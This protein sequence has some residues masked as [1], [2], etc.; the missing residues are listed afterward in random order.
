MSILPYICPSCFRNLCLLRPLQRVHEQQ[1]L[2]KAPYISLTSPDSQQQ[3]QQQQQQEEEGAADE[4][5][6]EARPSES[7]ARPL[8]MPTHLERRQPSHVQLLFDRTVEDDFLE[9]LTED[10]DFSS[11]PY[12]NPP[13]PLPRRGRGHYTSA[14]PVS[15]HRSRARNGILHHEEAQRAGRLLSRSERPVRSQL[16]S[17]F[18]SRPQHPILKDKNPRIRKHQVETDPGLFDGFFSQFV[19]G[20]YSERTPQVASQTLPIKF[21]LAEEDTST[22]QDTIRGQDIAAAQTSAEVLDPE[23]EAEDTSRLSRIVAPASPP[24]KVYPAFALKKHKPTTRPPERQLALLFHA[25]HRSRDTKDSHRFHSDVASLKKR[26]VKQ[27]DCNAPAQDCYS[28]FL[29]LHLHQANLSVAVWSKLCRSMINAWS[30]RMNEDIPS[31]SKFLQ[32][33]KEDGISHTE[34]WG[35]TIR[36]VL[37]ITLNR[38]TNQ[39]QETKQRTVPEHL[40]EIVYLWSQ[41]F[42]HHGECYLRN[43]F[44]TIEQ[45]VGVTD[46]SLCL[47]SEQMKRLKNQQC[48]VEED[49]AVILG[50]NNFLVTGEWN[51]HS[52]P[53]VDAF[54][55]ISWLLLRDYGVKVRAEADDHEIRTM[56]D[57]MELI[58]M[59]P[60]LPAYA[61]NKKSVLHTCLAEKTRRQS[62]DYLLRKVQELAGDEKTP[63][64]TSPDVSSQPARPV[65]LEERIINKIDKALKNSN[66]RRLEEIWRVAEQTFLRSPS[67]SEQ[68]NVRKP[69]IST[70][71]TISSRVYKQFFMAYMALQRPTRAIEVWNSMI[72]NGHRP[73]LSHWDAMLN[74]CGLAR[75]LDGALRM[76][77][78]ALESD[79]KPDVKLWTTRIHSLMS[80]RRPDLGIA[81]FQEMAL[82]WVNKATATGQTN[83]HVVGNI[84]D[85]PKPN[86]QCLNTAISGLV[87]ARKFEDLVRLISWS[88]KLGIKPDS[89]TF[90]PLIQIALKDENFPLALKALQQMQ[91][92]GIEPDV[93]TFTLVLDMAIKRDGISSADEI[94]NALAPLVSGSSHDNISASGPYSIE[95][96]KTIELE[97]QISV[98]DPDDVT[99]ASVT[100][101]ADF[102]VPSC[103][104]QYSSSLSK[105][106]D[107]SSPELSNDAFDSA[108]LSTGQSSSVKEKSA[109]A[110]LLQTMLAN[111]TLKPSPHTYTTLISGLLHSNPP[112]PEA[113]HAL[114]SYISTHEP[115]ALSSQLY[116][117]LISFHFAQDP[118]E[119]ESVKWLWRQ[120]KR[121]GAKVDTR[122]FERLIDGWI[123]LGNVAARSQAQGVQ[124]MGAPHAF[125]AWQASRQKGWVLGFDTLRRLLAG[126]LRSRLY[127]E[128]AQIVDGVREQ[129]RTT[130]T[131]HYKRAGKGRESF[132]RLVKQAGLDDTRS[133]PATCEGLYAHEDRADDRGRH[134]EPEVF[135]APQLAFG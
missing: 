43:D 19:K 103:N 75:D 26:L 62:K 99:Q 113:A 39:G 67:E 121:K 98:N 48:Q 38:A 107:P 135:E 125:D 15:L 50:I 54:A 42:Q 10:R 41:M 20:R 49:G 86:T 80:C 84:G 124:A 83:Y 89:Y 109:L 36:I 7:P 24:R 132:W 93:A 35:L 119:L 64:V 112:N 25:K 46:L 70:G 71:L 17:W 72:S 59:L 106:I 65:S 51:C 87:A 22:A 63:N 40:R 47:R 69:S 85:I 82:N 37:A 27:L 73:E 96:P 116:T 58:N 94:R 6:E 2:Q 100:S 5:A 130:G 3:Q 110:T 129:E 12:S 133:S 60:S 52:R 101:D 76:W 1:W 104:H 120:G 53:N 23:N 97:S 128:A 102:A 122:F 105:L 115:H 14:G 78:K 74:G 45:V 61:H 68:P 56:D 8:H 21:N 90:N 95:A 29:Q 44:G 92:S 11:G 111:P 57:F 32:Q 13:P 81:A 34:V 4:N 66:I 134:E 79:I 18:G 28:T 31:P 33:L 131:G 123:G 88:R 30:F 117:S 126:L 55:L 91:A 108:L 118:P 77:Q 127:D 114:L 16:S 9:R